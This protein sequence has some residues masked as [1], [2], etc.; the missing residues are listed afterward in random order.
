M[1]RIL[2]GGSYVGAVAAGAVASAQL[3]MHALSTD[4]S[5]AIREVALPG[6]QI[7]NVPALVEPLRPQR[8]DAVRLA[9][10]V[11]GLRPDLRLER[12]GLFRW[13]GDARAWLAGTWFAC[14][15][16]ARAWLACARHAGSRSAHRPHGRWH[17]HHGVRPAERGTGTH[18]FGGSPSDELERGRQHDGRPEEQ[19]EALERA[20]DSGGPGSTGA[21]ACFE[22]RYTGHAGDP[23]EPPEAGQAQA[24]QAEAGQASEARRQHPASASAV[25]SR[26]ATGTAAQRSGQRQ[27]E[28]QGEGQEVE[29]AG[30]SR[31]ARAT[32]RRVRRARRGRQTARRP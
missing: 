5:A 2:I 28:R 1:R 11:H 31:F 21:T 26:P 15:R 3:W 17:G 30:S 19:A 12:L 13:R 23:A 20:R 7:R 25:Q 16:H 32:R 24:G 10:A 18:G 29:P 27:R 4:E 6:S 22:A 14:A 8:G 9:V